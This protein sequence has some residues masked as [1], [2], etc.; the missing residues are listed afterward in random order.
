VIDLAE[1]DTSL[2]KV[3]NKEVAGPCPRC[4]GDDRFHVQ[5]GRRESGSWMCRHCWPAEEK[6]WGD[7]IEYLRQMR[8]MSFTDASQ[9]IKNDDVPQSPLRNST[10]ASSRYW[11][12]KRRQERLSIVT[13]EAAEN[14]WKDDWSD[15]RDYLSGRG[16]TEEI[17][18]GAHLGAYLWRGVRVL[19]IPWFDRASGQYWRVTVR[20]IRPGI[21]HD[22]RYKNIDGSIVDEGLYGAE[23][24]VLTRPVI[25][26]EGELDALSIIQQAGDLIGVVS[27]G[28][29]SGSRDATWLMKLIN[30][31]HVFV[32]F[33][34]DEKGEEAAKYW[35][36][37][38]P[39]SS[40]WYTPT[41]KDANDMLQQGVNI[42]LWVESALATLNEQPKSET[43][44]QIAIEQP[45]E[46]VEEGP[47]VRF[48]RTT[49]EDLLTGY[50]SF[51]TSQTT[52]SWKMRVL[53][54]GYTL[55]DRVRDYCQ[56]LDEWESDGW[57]KS[58]DA[59]ARARSMAWTK[60]SVDSAKWY[61]GW[62][63]F[64]AGDSDTRPAK[65]WITKNAPAQPDWT[66][67]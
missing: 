60:Q 61:H 56:E 65:P 25:L 19:T 64:F 37:N 47:E 11:T 20:D 35:L 52:T 9:F 22:K 67:G 32:A 31:S 53:P 46:V 62:M 39:N 16:F 50:A 18:R 49:N 7:A 36:D 41:G 51:L 15:V 45:V 4:K 66:P 21:P 54:Q 48:N 29:T 5:P 12:P 43:N 10:I 13:L 28:S 63:A 34:S 24:L 30:V 23:S 33:D 58:R 6:G 8:G 59:K 42:R 14:L 1:Q 44:F 2:H 3:S 38:L 57:V 40:R 55:D 17:I 27:T 26:V